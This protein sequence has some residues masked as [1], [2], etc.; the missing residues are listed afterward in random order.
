MSIYKQ[1]SRLKLRVQTTQGLLQVEDLW[2]L[3][4]EKL[5]ALADD[6]QEKVE[7]LTKYSRRSKTTE[8]K[9][10]VELRLRLEI[11]ED[12]IADKLQAVDEKAAE[13]ERQAKRQVLLGLLE[14]KQQEALAG[15]TAEEL[16]IELKALDV[17]S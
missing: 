11:L 1:A 14:K 10:N 4:I 9:E 6:L 5:E 12:I 17:K 2:N 3:S 13:Q 8:S 7:K 16:M 15:K